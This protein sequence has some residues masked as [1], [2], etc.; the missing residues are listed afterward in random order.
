MNYLFAYLVVVSL[1]YVVILHVLIE[2]LISK[3]LDFGNL[4]LSPIFPSAVLPVQCS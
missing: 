3:V 4:E 2:G 1:Y